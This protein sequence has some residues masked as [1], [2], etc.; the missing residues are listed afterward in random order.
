LVTSYFSTDYVYKSN[1]L[2]KNGFY[3]KNGEDGILYD[4]SNIINLYNSEI[5]GT[6][7][8]AYN[9]T[10][11]STDGT[12]ELIVQ[13][14]YPW[15]LFDYIICGGYKAVVQ[16]A[17]RELADRRNDALVLA[18][19]G[20]FYINPNE[21]LD[22]R[23]NQVPWNTFN[24][25]LYSQFREVFDAWNGKYIWMTPVYHAIERHL[26]VDKQ[27]WIAEPVAGIEKGAISEPIN[28]AY[29]PSFIKMEDLIEK[30]VNPTIYEPDGIYILT[31]LTT[32]KRL[33][34][35]QRA[36]AVKFVHF[37]KKQLPKLLKDLLQ[38]KA[39]KYWLN[40]AEFRVKNY[41][42]QFL[43]GKAIDRYVAITDYS[44]NVEFDELRSEMNIYLKIRP[45]R[46]IEAINVFIIVT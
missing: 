46:V 3:L 37:L 4:S 32:Y 43:D 16:N 29:K 5:V 45:I 6:L 44:V 12:I 36:H 19:T 38:R 9:G 40:Q 2:G 17:A 31:Q 10:L 41:M 20:G 42:E 18:D 28:L 8:R 21:D 25:M 14:V 24:A 1:T 13:D 26:Y 23:L 22:A 11:E 39:T 15:Y 30:G 7:V 35:L 33:S 27:Y 34:I